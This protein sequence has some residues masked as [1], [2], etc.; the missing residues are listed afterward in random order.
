LEDSYETIWCLIHYN[1]NF[2]DS[3]SKPRAFYHPYYQFSRRSGTQ[4]ST[5]PR[6]KWARSVIWGGPSP[7]IM[8]KNAQTMGLS[9]LV[10]GPD[11]ISHTPMQPGNGTP[12]KIRMGSSGNICRKAVRSL[13]SRQ[14][15]SSGSWIDEII[16]RGNARI[17]G[18]PMKSF[19]GICYL[20]HLRVESKYS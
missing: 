3:N 6:I 13:V 5:P 19:L 2:S 7:P 14:Q 18:H 20:L 1:F 8:A 17:I 15:R 16:G 9:P 4:C 12:T 10:W 11:F